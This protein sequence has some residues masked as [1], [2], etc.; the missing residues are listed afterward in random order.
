MCE[1]VLRIPLSYFGVCGKRSEMYV[2]GETGR[3]RYHCDR[4]NVL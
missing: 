3:N 1:Q 2:L 4:N